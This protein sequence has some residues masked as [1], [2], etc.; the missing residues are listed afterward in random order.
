MAKKT[1]YSGIAL[2]YLQRCAF[3]ILLSGEVARPFHYIVGARAETYRK[4]YKAS[5]DHFLERLSASGLEYEDVWNRRGIKTSHRGVR[6]K[7]FKAVALKA[8]FELQIQQVLGP[9]IKFPDSRP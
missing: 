2:G 5:W 8:V 3:A 6:L 9:E 7:G 4:Y 1:R